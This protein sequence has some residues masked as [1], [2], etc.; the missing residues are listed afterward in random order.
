MWSRSGQPAWTL[1]TAREPA[2]CCACW[3]ARWPA[4][5]APGGSTVR[6]G[7]PGSPPT[8][9][10]TSSCMPLLTRLLQAMPSELASKRITF[11][12]FKQFR[13]MWRQLHLLS[14]EARFGAA[15]RLKLGVRVQPR[16]NPS[17]CPQSCTD[18]GVDVPT[19]PSPTRSCPGVPA[20]HQRAGGAAGVCVDGTARDGHQAG[21]TPG[22]Q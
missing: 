1:S 14:G 17:A 8:W 21:A 12:E 20:E 22:E 11:A 18:W 5:S 19:S 3:L 7:S 15:N 13:D 4:P 10:I 2:A 6:G 16:S 9:A